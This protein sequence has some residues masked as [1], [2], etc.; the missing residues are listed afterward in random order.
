MV[1]CMTNSMTSRHVFTSCVISLY[2]CCTFLVSR[3]LHDFVLLTNP[4]YD[5]YIS[6]GHF[7]VSCC[8]DKANFLLQEGCG[9]LKV[10]Q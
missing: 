6:C 3:I 10:N 4:R 1:Y 2:K 7:F 9:L 8:L 5:M